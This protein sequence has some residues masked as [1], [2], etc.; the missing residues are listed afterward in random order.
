MNNTKLF[1]KDFLLVVIGQIISL[2]G[3]QILR[4]ALPLYLLNQT[5]SAALFGMISAIAFIPMIVLCP[6]GGIIAD[7]VNKRNIMVIL[8]FSTSAIVTVLCI[9]LGKV[10]IVLLLLI[11]M[12]LLY[13]IQGAY[14][15]AVQA[16]IPSLVPTQY[17][18]PANAMINLVN[19]L[20]GLIGPVIGGAVYSLF[21][22]TPIL[23][24]SIICFFA[25]AFMEIFIHIP[26]HKQASQG[27]IFTIASH[28]LKESFHYIRH[29]QPS[30]WQGSL[31]IAGINMFLSAL[32]MIGLPIVVTQTL[33]FEHVDANRMYGY[34]QGALAAGSLIGGMS[35]GALSKKLKAHHCPVILLL[36][37]MTL[38]P[39]GL[40]LQF[41]KSTMIAYWII[42]VSCFFMMLFAALFSIQM[43]AYLQ[44]MA[45]KHLIGKIISCAMCIG[46]CASPLGQ[47]MY[48]GFFQLMK[49]Y[50]AVPFYFAGCVSIIITLAS[51]RYSLLSP[52]CFRQ[53]IKR[54]NY[55][56]LITTAR[57]TAKVN[58]I[59]N[60]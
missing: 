50:P 3:N 21:G 12:I 34:A 28:D 16:S 20:S 25:S 14:Q 43:M 46:M 15:P 27:N 33:S 2:F 47:G 57:M 58:R 26:F 30:I 8:D 19:S 41:A 17:I 6:I 55:N 60:I 53:R 4:F 48:G 42:V 45:P 37:T 40:A 23:Y 7:R 51:K 54:C 52:N 29:E 59:V 31:L 24:M 5:G 49:A 44:M 39:I 9:L 10:D 13:G 36:C 1:Q 11:T 56:T 38:F 35:A 18:M 32:I 22:L